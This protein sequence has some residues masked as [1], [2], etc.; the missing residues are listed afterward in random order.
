MDDLDDEEFD[1]DDGWETGDPV[2]GE[3]GCLFP[4]KCVMPGLHYT[5][6]CHTAEDIL[7]NMQENEWERFSAHYEKREGVKPDRDSVLIQ[8][9]F[10]YFCCGANEDF[11]ELL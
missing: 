6:D 2:L 4:D 1:G 10:H 5:A 9:F 3:E 7:L 11:S 8:R